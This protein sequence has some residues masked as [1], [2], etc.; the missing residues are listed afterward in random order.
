MGD[1]PGSATGKSRK[2]KERVVIMT[3]PPGSV[4]GKSWKWKERD[5]IMTDPPGSATG[6]SRKWKERDVIMTDPLGSVTGKNE[7]PQCSWKRNESS[8]TTVWDVISAH[9]CLFSKSTRRRFM[10]A[11]FICTQLSYHYFNNQE[12]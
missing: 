4:T 6:K 8:A 1:P 7:D 9:S 11:Y 5:V 2:W 3:D 12:I 10:Q